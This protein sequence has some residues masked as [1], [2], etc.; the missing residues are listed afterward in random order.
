VVSNQGIYMNENK[1]EAILNRPVPKSM[2]DVRSFH[3]LA[4]FYR[5]FIKGFSAVVA[6]LTNCLKQPVLEW[7]VATQHS[8]DAL[9]NA[10]TTT[11]CLQ[12]PDFEK[13]FK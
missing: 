6:P 2:A 12:V 4:T 5:R 8:F 9:K 1:V 10:L 3:G 11:P 7:I 13:T